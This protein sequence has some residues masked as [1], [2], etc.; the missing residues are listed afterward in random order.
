MSYSNTYTHGIRKMPFM[1]AVALTV[2]FVFVAEQTVIS[3]TA[4][5]AVNVQQFSVPR[6]VAITKDINNAGSPQTVINIKDV[7]D[8]Y[9]AQESIVQVLE[10]LL[11]NYDVRVVGI[12]GSEGPIDTSLISAFPDKEAKKLGA[13]YLMD[14]GKISAGEFFA[15]LSDTPVKLY[16]IDNSQLYLK[17]YDSFLNLLQYKKENLGNVESLKKAL[18]DLEGYVFSPDLKAL[19]DN[20]VLSNGGDMKFTKRWYFVKELGERHDIPFGDYP[21]INALMKAVEM[22]KTLN[23]AATNAERDELLNVLSKRLNRVPLEELVLKSIAFKLGRISKSQFYSYILSVAKAEGLDKSAYEDLDRYSEYVTLY[24]SIDIAL[25]MDEIENYESK[26]KEKLFRNDEERELSK[27]L[28]DVEILRNLYDVQLTSGQLKY[29]MAYMADFKWKIF[30]DFIKD[31]YKKYG[32]VLP[33]D[34]AGASEVFERL[35]KAIT[36]YEAATARN[37]AMVTNTI[38]MMKEN[39]VKT[40]AI[41]TGGFHTRGITDILKSDRISY[42]ILLP[43]FNAAANKRPYVTVLTSKY[44]EYKVDIESG[45]YLALTSFLSTNDEILK[46]LGI[47]EETL[48]ERLYDLLVPLIGAYVLELVAK[49][50]SQAVIDQKVNAYFDALRSRSENEKLYNRFYDFLEGG[51]LRYKTYNANNRLYAVVSKQDSD[52]VA[53]SIDVKEGGVNSLRVEEGKTLEEAIK[54]AVDLKKDIIYN[55]I[56]NKLGTLRSL[57]DLIEAIK[58]AAKAKGLEGIDTYQAAVYVISKMQPQMRYQKAITALSD[59]KWQNED[60]IVV[61]IQNGKREQVAEALRFADMLMSDITPSGALS[62]ADISNMTGKMAALRFRLAKADE[63]AGKVTVVAKAATPKA[64]VKAEE[65]KAEVAI[66]PDAELRQIEG[67]RARAIESVNAMIARS[68]RGRP[69]ERLVALGDVHGDLEQLKNNLREAGVIDANDNWSGGKAV[70][71]QIGDTIDR[72]PHSLATY[73]YLDE[74][75]RQAEKEGGEVVRLLGNHELMLIQGDHRYLM[76]ALMEE[77]VSAKEL[78]NKIKALK[79]KIT[80]D[81]ATGRIVGA[82][83]ANGRLFTHAGLNTDIR[84]RLEK[85][86][87]VK[88]GT[89]AEEKVPV[90]MLVEEINDI[91]KNSALRNVYEHPIFDADRM[92][93]GK[94]EVGGIFW[95]DYGV[96]GTRLPGDLSQVVGHTIPAGG[97]E[98][99]RADRATDPRIIN[100]DVALTRGYADRGGYNNGH[101]EM[102]IDRKTASRDVDAMSGRRGGEAGSV[103]FVSAEKLSRIENDILSK[104]DEIND[105]D[106]KIQEVRAKIAAVPAVEVKAKEVLPAAPAVPV[107]PIQVAKV[108][109]EEAEVAKEKAEAEAT[110]TRGPTEEAKEAVQPAVSKDQFSKWLEGFSKENEADL[111]NYLT[112]FSQRFEQDDVKKLIAE[113]KF[114]EIFNTIILSRLVDENGKRKEV[115]GKPVMLSEA[116]L[117]SYYTVA[118]HYSLQTTKTGASVDISDVQKKLY[119]TLKNGGIG[120]AATAAGKTITAILTFAMGMQ[121]AMQNNDSYGG[122]YLAETYAAVKKII[123]GN[124]GLSV[125]GMKDAN[126]D[127]HLMTHAEL[128]SLFGI[129]LDVQSSN[130]SEILQARNWDALEAALKDRSIIKVIDPTQFGFGDAAI[131]ALQQARPELAQLFF[132]AMSD[133]FIDEV[134]R[135]MSLTTQYIQQDP[136]G[137]KAYSAK[138]LKQLG[139]LY[140]DLTGLWYPSEEDMKKGKKPIQLV[141]ADSQDDGSRKKAEEEFRKRVADGEWVIFV[142]KRGGKD[143]SVEQVSPVVMTELGN[144]IEKKGYSNQMIHSGINA[145]VMNWSTEFAANASGVHPVRGGIENT[146]HQDAVT[147][148]I[149]TL[150]AKKEL[151]REMGELEDEAKRLSSMLEKVKKG[152]ALSAE[153]TEEVNTLK[154]EAKLQ[155][156]AEALSQKIATDRALAEEKRKLTANLDLK[157]LME[158]LTLESSTGSALLKRILYGMQQ[159]VAA[160]SQDEIDKGLTVI[161]GQVKGYEDI[162]GLRVLAKREADGTINVESEKEKGSVKFDSLEEGKWQKALQN[163]EVSVRMNDKTKALEVVFRKRLQISGAS[164]TWSPLAEALLGLSTTSIDPSSLSGRKFDKVEETDFT[165]EGVAQRALKTEE[166]RRENN[167]VKLKGKIT[168]VI[169]SVLDAASGTLSAGRSAAVFL[170]VKKQDFDSAVNRME[171]GRTKILIGQLIGAVEKAKHAV[172]TFNSNKSVGDATKTIKEAIGSIEAL[173]KQVSDPT[174]LGKIESIKRSLESEF[175]QVLSTDRE[176]AD[177]NKMLRLC[178]DLMVKAEEAEGDRLAALTEPANDGYLFVIDEMI[179][180]AMI[181]KVAGIANSKKFNGKPSLILVNNLENAQQGVDFRGDFDLFTFASNRTLREIVQTIGR[182]T[183]QDEDSG[184]RYIIMDE[185]GYAANFDEMDEVIDEFA[186]VMDV[187]AADW[188]RSVDSAFKSGFIT[189][190]KAKDL[191][192]NGDIARAQGILK[193]YVGKGTKAFEGP[194]GAE[195]EMLLN[196]AYLLVRLDVTEA[197]LFKAEEELRNHYKEKVKRMID[198]IPEGMATRKALEEAYV[199]L[200]N[201]ERDETKD[202]NKLKEDLGMRDSE[203]IKG[204]ARLA[205]MVKSALKQAEVAMVMVKT[206]LGADKKASKEKNEYNARLAEIDGY[207]KE[208][209]ESI[210]IVESGKK[211]EGEVQPLML[212]IGLKD[213]VRSAMKL[214]NMM[215][216]ARQIG[217]QISPMRAVMESRLP[218]TVNEAREKTGTEL[219]V[220]VEVDG[221]KRAVEVMDGKL[222]YSD[223]KGEVDLNDLAPADKN[224]AQALMD[225]EANLVKFVAPFTGNL[226]DEGKAYWN[227]VMALRGVSAD[228][229]E[230]LGAM[231]GAGKPPEGDELGFAVRTANWLAD[232]GVYDLSDMSTSA[233]FSPAGKALS[234]A[235]MFRDSGILGVLTPELAGKLLNKEVMSKIARSKDPELEM[236]SFVIDATA[237]KDKADLRKEVET[238][239]AAIDPR[240]LSV[241][242]KRVQAY[243]NMTEARKRLEKAGLS[244]S[245]SMQLAKDKSKVAQ[246]FDMLLLKFGLWKMQRQIDK[247]E[248][249]AKG[250]LAAEDRKLKE[251]R[252]R[253]RGLE[254]EKGLMAVM[255]RAQMEGAVASQEEKVRRMTE[256][257]ALG[258][259]PKIGAALQYKSPWDENAKRAVDNQMADMDRPKLEDTLKNIQVKLA[260]APKVKA[261]DR[262]ELLT[263]QVKILDLLGRPEE[264]AGAVS[265]LLD[266]RA[267]LK[268]ADKTFLLLCA[269]IAEKQ[270]LFDQVVTIYDRLLNAEP[271][272]VD[273]AKKAMEAVGRRAENIKKDKEEKQKK[274]LSDKTSLAEKMFR[275][276]YGGYDERLKTPLQKGIQRVVK[277]V[278][279]ASLAAAPFLGVGGG[280]IFALNVGLMGIESVNKNAVIWS[281]S[282]AAGGLTKKAGKLLATIPAAEGAIDIKSLISAAETARQNETVDKRDR[283]LGKNGEIEKLK[284]ALGRTERDTD[285]IAILLEMAALYQDKD[286]TRVSGGK[287]NKI[288]EAL[289]E[290]VNTADIILQE[291]ASLKEVMPLL[292]RIQGL[293]GNQDMIDLAGNREN[294]GKTA[295]TDVYNKVN[296]LLWNAGSLAHDPEAIKALVKDLI[297]SGNI[298]GAADKVIKALSENPDKTEFFAIFETFVK[299]QVKPG[300]EGLEP[301][302][303]AVE[304]IRNGDNVAAVQRL[305]SLSPMLVRTGVVTQKDVMGAVLA[306]GK[307]NSYQKAAIIAEM[308]DS[309]KKDV[310]NMNI[311]QIKG[312]RNDYESALR[313][314]GE[315]VSDKR[316]KAMLEIGLAVICAGEKS[317]DFIKWEQL[318]NESKTHLDAAENDMRAASAPAAQLVNLY[319]LRSNMA[320]K[321]P[322]EGIEVLRA[323][324][325]M[326]MGDMNMRK[327]IDGM[328]A[329]KMSAV[330]NAYA[331]K[332]DIKKAR[333][334]FGDAL[335]M[336]RDSVEANMGLLNIVIGESNKLIKEKEAAGEAARKA[337]QEEKVALKRNDTATAAEMV[338]KASEQAALELE[339]TRAA[340]AGIKEAAEIFS[341]LQGLA[342]KAAEDGDVGKAVEVFTGLCD[343][344]SRLSQKGGDILEGLQSLNKDINGIM[345]N[346]SPDMQEWLRGA[347]AGAAQQLVLP[348][349]APAV[350][351]AGAVPVGVGAQ[352]EALMLDPA[353]LPA[354]AVGMNSKKGADLLTVQ[355]VEA[356]RSQIKTSVTP[357]VQ[358][359]YG[360]NVSVYV[361]GPLASVLKEKGIVLNDV[362][363]TSLDLYPSRGAIPDDMVV[364]LFDTSETLFE[365]HA[366]N[367]LIGINK[368]FIDIIKT[369]DKQTAEDL[370]VLGISHELFHEINPNASEER[371]TRFSREVF[372]G[373]SLERQDAVLSALEKVSSKEAISALAPGVMI[374]VVGMDVADFREEFKDYPDVRFTTI[375][376]APE[377]DMTMRFRNM[378]GPVTRF[379]VDMS[380]D[381]AKA[382]MG[383]I[384]EEGRIQAFVAAN[385]YLA[386]LDAVSAAKLSDEGIRIAL[387]KTAVSITERPVGDVLEALVY[388]AYNVR[389]GTVAPSAERVPLPREEG[390]VRGS[391]EAVALSRERGEPVRGLEDLKAVGDMIKGL[392]RTARN[393]AAARHEGMAMAESFEDSLVS[394]MSNL[395]GKNVVSGEQAIVI[396]ARA[397]SGLKLDVMAPALL[398]LAKKG[399]KDN[400]LRVAVITD[401]ANP[402]SKYIAPKDMPVSL[403]DIPGAGI[404]PDEDLPTQLSGYLQNIPIKYISVATG[405]SMTGS[406]VGHVREKGVDSANFVIAGRAAVMPDDEDTA[407]I[408]RLIPAIALTNL[409]SRAVDDRKAPSITTVGCPDDVMDMIKNGLKGLAYILRPLTTIDIGREIRDAINSINKVAVSL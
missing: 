270:G 131:R 77:G 31:G 303:G 272:N 41:V 279:M 338:L 111:R 384:V 92:R 83:F 376:K 232:H 239:L 123:E 347:L 334:F 247:F 2:A 169:S 163:V 211:I 253:L 149:L 351:A 24:E 157:A 16:G 237:G 13:E 171:K 199:K 19:M 284:D 230:A 7:H 70:L 357:Y 11:V 218:K 204:K 137:K 261:A 119:E 132:A 115:D 116:E 287:Y 94:A 246:G 251:M 391:A 49:G 240:L 271:D 73:E 274:A 67:E 186:A 364:S 178:E 352:F 291:G 79:Q 105:L 283:I 401:V 173:K 112:E 89:K 141:I 267:F 328:L 219:G 56:K 12:E 126:G 282:W 229:R 156:D 205:G 20:S 403:V 363:K 405:D 342:K 188:K 32:L 37:A 151:E 33:A 395:Y 320:V 330:G 368:F 213:L 322:E 133:V 375:E 35:P 87:R 69:V 4:G 263:Y 321:T 36:F 124:T 215:I 146:E 53:V 350:P 21:N 355:G 26:I 312:L 125:P 8:N 99:I 371:A 231:A 5:N 385:P 184:N 9:G 225:L 264:A 212:A 337:A 327:N 210:E 268:S 136:Q 402:L 378:P 226:T 101:L 176:K 154:G 102:N 45:K 59:A 96:I 197:L 360:K 289:S 315:T 182:I 349:A 223:D 319:I 108:E 161:I 180:P 39:G 259:N 278:R 15:A 84:D 51:D 207:L 120:L 305:L 58:S 286:V 281:Q 358:M 370:F 399:A 222:V 374:G 60:N 145:M 297:G 248:K 386:G 90:R 280:I 18:V 214:D 323:A 40:A 383:R 316:I 325:D 361:E 398:N 65:K 367:G 313:S 30:L 159:Q 224:K 193:E 310:Y 140:G 152:G 203:I 196:A 22:E 326:T 285:K 25:L 117:L 409:L 348:I 52:P 195:K 164:A 209:E 166:V 341:K 275:Q 179:P 86:I 250:G 183:R 335:R 150:R 300:V 260:A 244:A 46:E 190:E 227:L 50:Y 256:A 362:I 404:R 177:T 72:G 160:V 189:E 97:E 23:Y 93:G 158:S 276:F 354:G 181:N 318:L 307:L 356:L 100:I 74:L 298:Y 165:K 249:T 236:W 48:F 200:E 17:N 255:S 243:K 345:K 121:R 372:S 336:N 329:Q 153:E 266:D 390:L 254:K 366:R 262:R 216:G 29:L 155:T 306:N 295:H 66:G 359:F 122:I 220:V 114:P 304:L 408:N 228:D 148:A 185:A 233:L 389:G 400:L 162:T 311:D 10:N 191:I 331:E 172:E 333:E 175:S 81:I 42:L 118:F 198:E 396:D 135:W 206:R 167:L 71:V 138:L 293:C 44:N 296:E 394:L 34:L 174:V 381:E 332:G 110:P 387:R 269:G 109:V 377:A 106:R 104:E 221:V 277:G 393:M 61:L 288:V 353:K 113:G 107:A 129:K 257:P 217:S 294:K 324:R 258:Y 194:Q 43:R 245:V 392:D 201:P 273:M 344:Y 234:L 208:I 78:G 98:L 292:A 343:L 365:D 314:L 339:K 54:G 1:R 128:A 346:V 373:F 235:A 130:L 38:K 64:E 407:A 290:A 301:L 382:N 82:Y 202:T 170:G 3:Q 88:N 192:D 397:A 144:L 55:A 168:Q 308:N 127:D 340:E 139:A 317:I 241:T 63:K 242:E 252:E 142:V 103:K 187:L 14:Q 265:A 85:E 302:K 309:L 27:L 62:Q 388:N 75:Q 406:V 91:L 68:D 76:Q 238:R 47:S 143:S 379:L 380:A 28:K 57:S 80:E 95:E 147:R 369:L 134:D 299:D 6:D